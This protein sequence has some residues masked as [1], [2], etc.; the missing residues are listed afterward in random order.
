M[1]ELPIG[2]FFSFPS[3]IIRTSTHIIKQASKE[4]ASGNSVIARRGVDRLTGFIA[5]QGMWSGVGAASA[6]MAGLTSDEYEA[7]NTLAE[8]PYS[9]QHNKLI[10]KSED[11]IHML[12][13]AFLTPYNLYQE[14]AS[15]LYHP[16]VT[17]ELYGRELDDSLK[18]AAFNVTGEL[19]EPYTNPAILSKS[20]MDVIH[21]FNDSD[22]RTPEGKRIFYNPENKSLDDLG[23]ATAH[24]A[25]ALIPGALQDGVKLAQ[26]V[27]GS[28]STINAQTGESR[29]IEL[30]ALANFTGLRF[31]KVDLDDMLRKHA[32]DAHWDQRAL[33][34]ISINHRTMPEEFVDNYHKRQESIKGIHQNLYRQVKAYQNLV[35]I[36]AGTYK[37]YEILKKGGLPASVSERIFIGHFVPESFSASQQFA[38]SRK[39]PATRKEIREGFEEIREI[40]RKYNWNYLFPN[41]DP[42]KEERNKK[43]KGGLVEDV[44][45]VP[46]E[47]D[48][49]I[50]KLTG[51][52]YNEQAGTAF[53][54][55]EDPVRRLG[56]LGGGLADNP[57]R[58]LGF[59]KGSLVPEVGKVYKAL[60]K[61]KAEG[62][63]T[64]EE[65][66]EEKEQRARTLAF[67]ENESRIHSEAVRAYNE[68]KETDKYKANPSRY[69]QGPTVRRIKL[70]IRMREKADRD[71]KSHGGRVLTALKRRA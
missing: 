58:R 20:I 32:S 27:A 23:M 22:G 70:N 36:G 41:E 64:N 38:L 8:T 67:T 51:R 47:P 31:R 35:G 66:D 43:D 42:D 9:N 28:P 6:T 39:S 40:K 11:N 13:L 46:E 7:I 37:P 59:G 4:I 48:E 1:R 15:D 60:R 62:G 30:E 17:G 10:L 34:R 49:R 14:L 25:A 71:K 54:D 65:T 50:D 26:T 52:P 68:F 63:L 53:I 21:A 45:Q 24:I 19:L 55:E 61:R 56:F 69:S 29:S 5:T 16:I 33:G 57:I 44:P 18:Q 3:E 12:D 2:N